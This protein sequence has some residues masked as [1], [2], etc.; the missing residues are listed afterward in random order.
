MIHSNLKTE[1]GLKF[2]IYWNLWAIDPVFANHIIYK[3]ITTRPEVVVELGGGLS[4]LIVAKTLSNMGIKHKIYSVDSDKTFIEETRNMLIAEGL[5]DENIVKLIHA[6][7]KNITISRNNYKW[8]QI[9]IKK[10]DF[11]KIDLLIVDGPIGSISKDARYPAIPFFKR[12]LKPGCSVLLDDFNR[13]DERNTAERWLNENE[14]LEFLYRHNSEKGAAELVF[15]DKKVKNIYKTLPQ[16]VSTAVK[17]NNDSLQEELNA[18][19]ASKT[20]RLGHKLAKV[21]RTV[22]R[23]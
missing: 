8:Y 14:H 16:P 4:T 21:H 19:Y 12:F 7:I 3:I 22:F 17:E 18:V 15:R 13:E 10:M 23:K 11:T 6:P 5:Y 9:D 2:P 20:W 1:L